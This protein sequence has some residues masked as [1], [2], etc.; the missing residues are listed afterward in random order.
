[1]RKCGQFLKNFMLIMALLP[2]LAFAQSW[3]IGILAQRGIAEAHERWQPW[4]DWLNQQFDEHNQFS[5]V[6]LDLNDLETEQ[7]QGVDFI[8][9]NQ[10]QFFYLNNK[11][12]RWLVTLKSLRQKQHDSTGRVGSAIFVR[13]ESNFY[14]LKDLKNKRISAVGNKAFGGFLLGYNELYNQGLMENK[15]FKPVFTGFPVDNTLFF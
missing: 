3:K 4:I 7:A 2:Q 10:S 6:T 5:L 11:E 9:S 15:D 12:V 8:L 14:Q 13:S 1:M